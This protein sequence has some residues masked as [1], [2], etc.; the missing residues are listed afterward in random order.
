MRNSSKF[1]HV[2]HSPDEEGEACDFRQ[3]DFELPTVNA[4]AMPYFPNYRLG[5]DSTLLSNVDPTY[6]S[7]KLRLYPNPVNNR[8]VVKSDHVI[9]MIYLHDMSGRAV[10]SSKELRIN[11]SGLDAGIYFV[12]GITKRGLVLSEKLVIAR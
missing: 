2:I 7:D 11:V 5:A 6:G 3:H 4:R 10:L 1:L 8:L 12:R 9:S